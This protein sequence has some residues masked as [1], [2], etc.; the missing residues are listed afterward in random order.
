[1]KYKYIILV[2]SLFLTF[3]F[4][5]CSKSPGEPTTNDEKKI[6]I[7]GSLSNGDMRR[8]NLEARLSGTFICIRFHADLDTCN[9]CLMND[10]NDVVPIYDQ[11][12]R[13]YRG[14]SL[15][16]DLADQPS[17]WYVL[18]LSNGTDEASAQFR[19]GNS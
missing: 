6:D 18:S 1:M 9:V 16:I 7:K 17:G 14:L 12:I 4:P 15:T 10:I 19:Y 2:I 13:T 8:P 11:N 5:S 3:L